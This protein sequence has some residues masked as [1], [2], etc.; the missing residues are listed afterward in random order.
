MHGPI[1]RRRH[2]LWLLRNRMHHGLGLCN[3][4]GLPRVGLA[5]VSPREGFGYPRSGH[6][7]FVSHGKPTHFLP[8]ELVE[9]DHDT[10]SE[11]LLQPLH[12]SPTFRG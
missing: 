11:P 4:T 1:Y 12:D 2:F 3:S 9:A 6:G 5:V 10:L 7:R 8:T